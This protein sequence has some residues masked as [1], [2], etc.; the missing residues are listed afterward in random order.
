MAR[1]LLDST[2]VVSA[3]LTLD[4][5]PSRSQELE[6]LLLEKICSL[7]FACFSTPHDIYLLWFSGPF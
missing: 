2:A 3:E 6:S 5:E 7:L 4:K 1:M